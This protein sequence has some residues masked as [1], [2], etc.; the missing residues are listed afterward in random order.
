MQTLS[1]FIEQLPEDVTTLQI[2]RDINRAQNGTTTV[3][4]QVDRRTFQRSTCLEALVNELVADKVDDINFMETHRDELT[5]L[6]EDT[7]TKD[8]TV[9][10]QV[11]YMMAAGDFDPELRQQIKALLREAVNGFTGS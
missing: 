9:R 7:P 2:V 3:T 11:Q 6:I 8:D 10:Q 5:D 1:K 4:V